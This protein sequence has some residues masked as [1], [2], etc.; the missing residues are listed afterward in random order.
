MASLRNFIRGVHVGVIELCNTSRRNAL[1][2]S[3]L[4]EL[5]N[6]VQDM[7]NNKDVRVVVIQNTGPV[8]S[9]GHD[10]REIQSLQNQNNLVKLKELF[11]ICSRT[12]NYITESKKPYVAKVDGV[13]TAAGCQLVASKYNSFCFH[14]ERNICF[15]QL[16]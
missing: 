10:L 3:T 7:E 13:A 2:R 5:Y 8:F 15:L 16:Q 4:N 9:S 1:S 11:E 12:M 6:A 14:S